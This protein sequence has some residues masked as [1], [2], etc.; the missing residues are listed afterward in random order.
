MNATAV[1][2]AVDDAISLAGGRINAISDLS[3]AEVNFANT[4]LELDRATE[5]LDRAW[6]YIGH[7]DSVSNTPAFREAHNAALPKV[8]EFYSAIPLNAELWKRLEAVDPQEAEQ[9][10]C[11]FGKRLLDET[12]ADFVESGA[13]LDPADK[14]RLLVI[15]NELSRVAQKFSENVLDSTNAWERF[16][17]NADDLRGMPE[18]ALDAAREDAIAKGRPDAWRLTLQAPSIIPVMQYAENE[19]LR[20]EVWEAANGIGWS[21]PYDNSSLVLEIL[22]LR[23]EKARLLGKRNF[24][25]CTTA[26]RMARSGDGALGFVEDLH[27][28]VAPAFQAEVKALRAFK[29]EQT[30]QPEEPLEPWETSYWAEKLRQQQYAFNEEEL[31]PWFPLNRVI[32]GLFEIAERLFSVRIRCAEP[33]SVWHE[34][35]M[36]FE[37]RDID[38]KLLGSFYTDWHPREGKRSGAWMNPLI[39]GVGEQPHV[40]L[41]CGNLSKGTGGRPALMT[42]DEV[43][44]IFHEFGHLLHHLLSRSPYRSLGGTNVAWDFVELPSQVM[45]NWCW[46]REALDLFARNFETGEPIPE[47]LFR[48]MTAARN[49]MAA[50]ATMRQLSFAKLDLEIHRRVD[51]VVSMGLEAFADKFLAG[52]RAEL[53]TPTPSML[54]RFTHLFGDATGYAAGYYSYKWAEVLDA[55]AFTRFRQEG[56]LNPDVGRALRQSILERGNTAPPEQLFRGFMGRDPDP[57]AL[58]RRDGLT[59]NTAHR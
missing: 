4:V 50:S 18:S 22:M 20:R 41:L 14:Q 5:S 23:D 24:A 2:E 21:D 36:Y 37:V 33:P 15:N 38:G 48:R 57:E 17:E 7:L 47:D 45:E 59:A 1:E 25:D 10:K 40:S 46:E 44:T 42:H 12:V 43:C 49:F 9:Q 27:A 29:A 6:S 13:R 31:R 3:L 34:S 30:G 8:T 19:S 11:G 32:D 51:E 39:L 28:R 55:D 58:L 56:V 53:K 54:R 16:I 26:R 35:V 52:Y